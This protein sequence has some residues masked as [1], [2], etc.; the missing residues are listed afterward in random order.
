MA[1][2]NFSNF[3]VPIEQKRDRPPGIRKVKLRVSLLQFLIMSHDIRGQIEF[4][5]YYINDQQLKAN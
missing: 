1:E 5:D 4:D 3:A 2:G